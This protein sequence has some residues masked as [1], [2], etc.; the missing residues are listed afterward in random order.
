MVPDTNRELGIMVQSEGL[1]NGWLEPQLPLR[2]AGYCI[3]TWW[4]LPHMHLLI[5]SSEPALEST[6][7]T[8]FAWGHRYII[9]DTQWKSEGSTLE[10]S[11]LILGL[12]TLYVEKWKKLF[13]SQI[14][15]VFGFLVCLGGL[16][17]SWLITFW[18]GLGGFT[19]LNSLGRWMYNR[20]LLTNSGGLKMF[21]ESINS[22]RILW[23]A[24][25]E[26]F[27]LQIG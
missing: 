20:G 26:L 2:G 25:E 18:W 13:I 8:I 17:V 12:L 19:W 4:E 15:N 22:L 7:V 10:I 11:I 1:C 23:L 6:P 14:N 24:K 21:D 16:G 27:L 9:Q 3:P 5:L